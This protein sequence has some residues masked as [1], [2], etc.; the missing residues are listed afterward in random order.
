MFFPQK[1]AGRGGIKD[2]VKHL[3]GGL[4]LLLQLNKFLEKNS[5]GPDNPSHNPCDTS[6]Q[7]FLHLLLSSLSTVFFFFCFVKICFLCWRMLVGK[8]LINNVLVDNF[9]SN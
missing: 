5:G 4:R 9:T 6:C 8:Y 3:R 1:N 7:L 2:V